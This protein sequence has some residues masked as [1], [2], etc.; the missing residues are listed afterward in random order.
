[1]TP[2]QIASDVMALG[3][4]L[5]LALSL[6]KLM[7]R[8]VSVAAANEQILKLASSR[9][10]ERTRKLCHAA[11][12]SYLDA[13]AAAITA[14]MAVRGEAAVL[15]AV[16][17]AFDETGAI[18]VARSRT[19]V[20]RGLVGTLL[21]GGAV[22]VAAADYIPRPLLGAAGAAGLATLGLFAQGSYMRGALARTR[23][24]VLPSLI[25]VITDRAD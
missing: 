13:I 14:G 21:V 22:G 8:K 6:Q 19:W 25:A 18:L 23:H 2:T 12:G 20:T 7:R 10:L 24:Q 4:L 9:N 16:H 17:G 5:V 1:M 15:A 11:P 3:G